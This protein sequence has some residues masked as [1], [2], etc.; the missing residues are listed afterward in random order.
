MSA[1]LDTLITQER[2]PSLFRY[3]Y[4]AAGFIGV[5]LTPDNVIATKEYE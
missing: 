4:L 1:A 2:T 5:L 3:D